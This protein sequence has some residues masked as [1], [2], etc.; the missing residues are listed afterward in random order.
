MTPEGFESTVPMAK[1]VIEQ[2]QKKCSS[3]LS[4]SRSR[5]LLVGFHSLPASLDCD[6]PAVDVRVICDLLLVS[7]DRGLHLFTLYRSDTKDD[8]QFMQYSHAAA[9]AL[10]RKLVMEGGC[11]EGFYVGY[12]IVHCSA[13]TAVD[14]S[15]GNSHYPK[16]YAMGFTREKLSA[17]LH[18]LVIV[19][20]SVPS[21]LSTK[22]GVR[23]LN[24]LTKEQFHLVKTKI[25]DHREYW[26]QGAAGTGKSIV[27]VEFMREL[28]RRDKNLEKNE[29][30][31]V[32]EN[33]GMRS[34]TE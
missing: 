8:G 34:K 6:M 23:F 22:L 4:S 16:S 19:L 11:R 2:I 24:L 21:T 28:R 7:R 26:V 30:L 5:G 18:A 33:K 20:A 1:S 3:Q 25:N 29:I 12:Q 14:L 10:K 15:I 31:Y 17:V 9:K 27:A 32:C 13:T